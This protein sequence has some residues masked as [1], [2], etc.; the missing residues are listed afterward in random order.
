MAAP[1]TVYIRRPRSRQIQIITHVTSIRR[2][3]WDAYAGVYRDGVNLAQGTLL[4]Y[5]AGTEP[6][7]AVGAGLP[8]KG[9]TGQTPDSTYGFSKIVYANSDEQDHVPYRFKKVRISGYIFATGTSTVPDPVDPP[10][11]AVSFDAAAATDIA[12]LA[13]D[14]GFENG[15]QVTVG[16]AGNGLTTTDIYTWVKLSATTGKFMLA[17][18]IVDISATITGVTMALVSTTA[19]DANVGDNDGALIYVPDNEDGTPAE[20]STTDP[21]S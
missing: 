3:T 15:D 10:F 20:I 4:P 5:D 12:T 6:T 21:R 9:L 11:R 1:D 8:V 17:G 16:T 13:S 14:Q 7:S 19:H 2:A 18:S